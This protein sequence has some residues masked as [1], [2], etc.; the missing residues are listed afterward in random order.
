MALVVVVIGLAALLVAVSGT[1]R[2]SGALRDKIIAEWIALNRIS[3]VRLNT[4]KFAQN[5]DAGEV[6]LAN[7]MWHYDTRYFDTSVKTMK[8]IDVRVYAGDAKTK[9]NPIAEA[10]GF[11]TTTTTPGA[12]STL[13][14]WNTGMTPDTAGSGSSGGALKGGSGNPTP[15]LPGQ[16]PQTPAAP[17]PTNPETP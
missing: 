13:V 4:N 5:T 15:S 8:R 16:F 7:R 6:Y 10:T 1:A 9:G 3:E 14:Q 2:T 17:P 12:S 11:Y